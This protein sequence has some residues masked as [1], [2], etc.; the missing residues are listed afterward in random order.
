MFGQKAFTSLPCHFYF[1]HLAHFHFS[2]V[3]RLY[4]LRRWAASYQYWVVGEQQLISCSRRSFSPIYIF[5]I[6]L[7]K[8]LGYHKNFLSLSLSFL[9]WVLHRE[10][11]KH[12]TYAQTYLKCYPKGGYL[13][14]GVRETYLKLLERR[15]V[16]PEGVRDCS[17]KEKVSTA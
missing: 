3:G 12:I 5:P 9:P 15:L 10:G 8:L 4:F 1:H 6:F 14:P 2:A 7:L 11:I 13:P 17:S 16:P